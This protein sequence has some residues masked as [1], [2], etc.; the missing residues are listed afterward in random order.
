MSD[1]NFFALPAFKPAEALVQLKRQLRDLK[2]TERG[3][4][5]ELEAQS[6]VELTAID[7]A[8]EARIVKR[9]A[10]TPE[11]TVQTLASS[12]EVRRFLDHLKTQLARWRSDE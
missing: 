5:F 1:D 4:H 12:A 3:S 7:N 2:L 6:V 11:W 8:I 10:R 9:P